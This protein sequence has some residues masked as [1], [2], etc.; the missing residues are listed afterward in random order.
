MSALDLLVVGGGVTGTATAS[1]A[2]RRGLRTLLV[3]QFH[4]G[5][6]HGSSHG[7]S[8]IIRL[9]Y[10]GADYVALAREAYGLW[11]RVGHDVRQRLLR[12]TGG[13]DFGSA[14]TPSLRATARTME[15]CDVEFERL[16]P[17]E[18][19]GRFPQLRPDPGMEGLYQQDAGVLDADTCV[20]AL[21]TDARAH[22]A[23]IREQAR[24]RRLRPVPGGVAADVNG[25]DVRAAAAVIA[26]GSW[27]RPLL[28]EMGRPLP[29]SVTREQVA[30]FAAPSTAFG[31]DRF[32]VMI[33]HRAGR[34]PMISM[35]PELEPG[36]GVKL[37]L[38][39]DGPEIDAGDLSGVVHEPALKRLMAHARH[40]LPGLGPLVRAETC[41][42]TMT[43]DEDFVLDLLP[44]QATIGVASACSGHGFKF[45]PVLG[46]IMVDLLTTGTTAR[47]VSRFSLDRPALAVPA[48]SR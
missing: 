37:M 32:P 12:G 41:R 34:P 46:E 44:G 2:A 27:T 5:N 22:G 47:P 15:A 48:S 13:L 17:D 4:I 29:L 8:R 10:D 39:R 33:E 18:L 11:R 16:S 30:Y 36:G 40:R 26:A 23:E 45:G 38:D 25:V 35:F 42:Y 21:A 24:V 1:A 20:R 14:D 6:P 19:A 31:P 3:E 28:A 7:P 9:A 43:P